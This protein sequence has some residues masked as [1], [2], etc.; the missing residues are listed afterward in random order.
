MP[1]TT[2]GLCLGPVG[3]DTVGLAR[4]CEVQYKYQ[5]PAGH[6]GIRRNLEG[7]SC[8]NY[9]NRANDTYGLPHRSA[10]RPPSTAGIAEGYYV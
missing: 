9:R 2:R 4:H 3:A 8:C 5:R 6:T 10:L 7:K 1:T